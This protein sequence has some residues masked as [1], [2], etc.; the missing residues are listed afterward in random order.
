MHLRI[1]AVSFF[2]KFQKKIVK[3]PEVLVDEMAI[4]FV[5]MTSSSLNLVKMCKIR[6]IL[7]TYLQ[8]CFANCAI[9]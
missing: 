7:F 5:W 8:A 6:F 9:L 2:Y 1:T 4:I 3:I